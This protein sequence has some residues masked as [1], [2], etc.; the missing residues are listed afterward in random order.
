MSLTH[1]SRFQNQGC[2]RWSAAA[3]GDSMLSQKNIIFLKC[4]M[5]FLIFRVMILAEKKKKKKMYCSVYHFMRENICPFTNPKEKIWQ[6]LV[7]QRYDR[8]SDNQKSR[9]RICKGRKKYSSYI[10]SMFKTSKHMRKIFT[11]F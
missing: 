2:F 1:I 4:H 11:K 7:F 8:L 5:Y 3:V 9:K 10:V 6:T